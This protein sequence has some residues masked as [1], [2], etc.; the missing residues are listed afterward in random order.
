MPDARP[1]RRALE[2]GSID[3]PREKRRKPPLYYH[4]RRRRVKQA[5]AAGATGSFPRPSKSR[6]TTEDASSCS[7][8]RRRSSALRPSSTDK[9][10]H[11]CLL[12]CGP[13]M[14]CVGG[15]AGVHDVLNTIFRGIASPRR[16]RNPFFHALDPFSVSRRACH[17]TVAGFVSIFDASCRHQ[18]GAIVMP[19]QP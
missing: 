1:P 3:L 5:G 2:S 15:N 10:T 16:A 18:S 9:T 11:G 14:R 8:F 7:F 13:Q 12:G 6:L 4:T 19:D 17:S